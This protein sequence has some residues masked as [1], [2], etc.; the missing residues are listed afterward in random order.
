MALSPVAASALVCNAYSLLFNL[1]VFGSHV[2][3]HLKMTDKSDIYFFLSSLQTHVC[4]ICVQP[5]QFLKLHNLH[6]ALHKRE[7]AARGDN[8]NTFPKL[9]LAIHRGTSYGRG[10]A[11]LHEQCPEVLA[12]K[13]RM[14]RLVSSQSCLLL[15]YSWWFMG[16]SYWWHLTFLQPWAGNFAEDWLDTTPPAGNS[17]RLSAL[18]VN[19]LELILDYDHIFLT[20][21]SC[22]VDKAVGGGYWCGCKGMGWK[23]DNCTCAY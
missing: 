10:V 7:E 22:A 2:T 5:G 13:Q 3:W 4:V 14:E 6:A 12:V 20:C 23:S 21:W 8:A 1:N 16:F 11:V 19:W 15:L 9:E 17:A 18:S